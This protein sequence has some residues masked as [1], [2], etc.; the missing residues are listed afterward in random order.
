VTLRG[1]SLPD[2]ERLRR[3]LEDPNVRAPISKAQ[4]ALLGLAH[5]AEEIAIL[6]GLDARGAS[7]ALAVAIAERKA[8]VPT[9]D[10]VWTGPETAISSARDTAV[11]VRELFEAARQSVLVAGFRFDHG[12]DILRPLHAAMKERG[13][14]ASVFI[15]GDG[16][17]R[18]VAEN[19]PFGDPVPETFFDPRTTAPGTHS[20]MHAKCVVVDARIALV[21]SANFTSRGQ[22]RNIEAGV[23]VDDPT[24]AKNLVAQW[25]ALVDAGVLRRA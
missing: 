16:V 8:A 9:P 24:F 3:A 21:T 7:A 12:A 5:V 13:V 15:D 25:R 18:F 19:W 10:L 14:Q 23:L 20:S 6:D 4:L 2:L 22:T 17:S 1:V 11:V